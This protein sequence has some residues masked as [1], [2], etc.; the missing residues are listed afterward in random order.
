M[1]GVND[2]ILV[3]VATYFCAATIR[4]QVMATVGFL[5]LIC[6]AVVELP[7]QPSMPTSGLSGRVV[8]NSSVLTP[9]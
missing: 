5:D 2:A 3:L 9:G 6:L 1:I 7:R 4:L 8:G